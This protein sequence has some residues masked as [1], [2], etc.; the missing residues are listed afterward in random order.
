MLVKHRLHIKH[1]AKLMIAFIPLNT[2]TGP[3]CDWYHPFT[4]G[5][6]GRAYYSSGVSI[7]T[8]PRLTLRP[9]L[10]LLRA[11]DQCWRKYSGPF[12]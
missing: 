2:H 5:E 4:D 3:R 9:S 1:Y 12:P 7:Q 6:T 10:M 11:T 8:Q